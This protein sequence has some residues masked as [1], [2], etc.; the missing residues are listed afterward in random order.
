MGRAV[1]QS[2]ALR[3]EQLLAAATALFEAHG[4]HTVS[5]GD[6]AS[7]V[8]LT[9]P[10]LY[11]HFGGKAD[12]LA[13]ALV[14]QMDMVLAAVT[15]ASSADESADRRLDGLLDRLAALV[16]EREGRLLWKRERR[17]LTAEAKA[18]FRARARALNTATAALIGDVRPDAS[19]PDLELLASAVLWT[20][21]HTQSYR[22][23]MDRAAAVEVLAGMAH[24]VLSLRFD[25]GPGAVANT[26]RGAVSSR[27]PIGR[28]ERVLDAATELFSEQGYHAVSMEQ[29]AAH[30]TTA[31]GT[32]Y[33]YFDTKADL[34]KA[35][36]LR[37]SEGLH[38]TT[39]H[40]LVAVADDAEALRVLVELYVELAFG[41][42]GRLF[43]VISA[44]IVYLSEAERETLLRSERQH[45]DEWIHALMSVRPELDALGAR[46]RVRTA[47]GVISDIAQTR[48]FRSRPEIEADT[49]RIATAILFA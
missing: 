11:R 47:V 19:R 33:Q 29:I 23:A 3:R 42:H 17:H 38:Y 18:E 46:A 35:A 41:L 32:M 30:S 37:G 15:A 48:R 27:R 40:R 43:A 6:I 2:N 45:I 7:A 1:K 12:I 44:D 25:S 31:L 9:G 8:G 24:A 14:E 20:Y 4:Y 39:A 21:S 28:R 10:A 13:Q 49:R 34:L 5:M 16:L 36:C 26:P 22:G